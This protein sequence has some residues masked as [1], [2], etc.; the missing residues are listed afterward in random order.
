M[1][2]HE[3]PVHDYVA[4]HLDNVVA[5]GGGYAQIAYFGHPETLVFL[6]YVGYG[7][8]TECL[9]FLDRPGGLRPRA[10]IANHNLA[11]Q[12]GLSQC[13]EYAQ[14]QCVRPVVCGNYQCRSHLNSF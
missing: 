14:P 9:Q 3:A 13:A 5:G 7:H 12:T 2:G 4:V 11:R 10:V 8:G 1:V 6:P